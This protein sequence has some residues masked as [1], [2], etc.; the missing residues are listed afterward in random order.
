MEQKFDDPPRAE[1][2]LEGRR[3]IRGDVT[4]DWGL[5]LQWEVRRDG[6][7]IATPQARADVAYELT[8]TAPGTYEVVRSSGIGRMTTR[9]LSKS[10]VLG[11]VPPNS[12]MVT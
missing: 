12:P 1:L 3:V 5:R 7:V 2:R 11:V 8:E 10:V 6:K 9:A 4:N